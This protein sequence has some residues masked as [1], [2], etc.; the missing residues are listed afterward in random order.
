MK[1]LALSFLV[2]L[3]FSFSA[4]A[5]TVSDIDINNASTEGSVATFSLNHVGATTH[6]YQYGAAALAK[7]VKEYTG[8]K[9]GV[10]VYPAS[11]IASGAKAIEFVQMGTLDM[12]LD[13]TMALENFVPEDGV[14][15][16]PFLFSTK[17]EVYEVLDGPVGEELKK[18]AENYGF[19]ILCWMDNGFR[20]MSNSVRKIEKP[21]DLKGMKL[22]TPESPVFIDTFTQLGAV[23]TAMAVSEVFSSMQLGIVDGQENPS[24]NFVNNKYIE[25]NKYYTLSHHIYTAE[26]LIMNIDKWE[27]LD[28][29]TKDAIQKAANEACVFEREFSDAIDAENIK[30]IENAGVEVTRLTPEQVDAFKTAVAPVYEKYK[31]QYGESIAKIQEAVKAVK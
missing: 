28:D 8:G 2:V 26:P 18:F 21:D 22:R 7:L 20:D 5:L 12:C 29:E 10:T 1:K 3:A 25:I 14:L 16:L 13:S 30:T 9:Y 19:K 27:S 17:K 11:Q 31:G 4:F 15:N 23:P 24:S 6:P